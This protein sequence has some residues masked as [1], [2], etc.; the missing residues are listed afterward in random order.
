VIVLT[1]RTQPSGPMPDDYLAFVTKPIDDV[2][3]F[4]RIVERSI[5]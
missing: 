1:A 4:M 2:Q 3:R 5:A